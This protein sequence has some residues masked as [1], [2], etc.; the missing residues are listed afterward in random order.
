MLAKASGEAEISASLIADTLCLV[1]AGERNGGVKGFDAK[2]LTV[3]CR[4]TLAE[5][6]AKVRRSGRHP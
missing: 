4:M 1:V 3:V 2:A 6:R 5:L